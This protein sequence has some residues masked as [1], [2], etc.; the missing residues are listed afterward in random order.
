MGSVT[1]TS[2]PRLGLVQWSAET[3]APNRTQFDNAFAAID[4]NV[5]MFLDN[6]MANRPAPG[7][8]GRFFYATDTNSLWYDNGTAWIPAN[9][10][11]AQAPSGYPTLAGAAQTFRIVGATNGGP[12]TSGTWQLGDTVVD[13]RNGCIWVCNA[14]GTPGGWGT[15]SLACA[16]VVTTNGAGGFSI[17]YPYPI[18]GPGGAIPVVV[19]G[20]IVTS[21]YPNNKGSYSNQ[22]FGEVTNTG[23]SGYAWWTTSSGSAT[24]EITPAVSASV[25][26]NYTVG[27]QA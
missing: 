20:G 6:T 8:V 26:I 1:I 23:W 4:A 7:V 21:T 16:T 5:A 10:Q 14:A 18:Y 12:P 22:V 15:S 9:P 13:T 24:S 2:S 3:D 11:A 19:T 25:T 27:V 17:N